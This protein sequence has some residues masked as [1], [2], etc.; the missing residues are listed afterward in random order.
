MTS[1]AKTSRPPFREIWGALPR[2]D[3]VDEIKPVLARY[4][5]AGFTGI[6]VE[7]DYLRWSWAPDPDSGFGGNWRLFNLFDFTR[8]VE[9]PRYRA[10]L[11]EIGAA[12]QAE[13]LELC[14]SFWLPKL[15]QELREYF[16]RHEPSSLGKAVYGVDHERETWC[17]CPGGTGIT[18]FAGMFDEFLTEFPE[19]T[20]LKISIKDNCAFICTEE[21]PHSQGATEAQNAARVFQV[22]QQSIADAGRPP[23]TLLVYPWFWEEGFEEEVVS[24]LKPGHTL[25][26]KYAVGSERA[27]EAGSPAGQLFDSSLLGE[28]PGPIFERWRERV[29]GDHIVDL[30]PWSNSMDA[31]F[32]A[33][34]PTLM[35]VWKRLEMLRDKGVRGIMDFEC[36][37]SPARSTVEAIRLFQET[38]GTIGSEEAAQRIARDVYGVA[39]PAPLV[40][41][42]TLVSRAWDTIPM[43]LSETGIMEPYGLS[44]R[45]GQAWPACAAS[46][47]VR[48]AF[49]EGE[50]GHH[51]HWFSP[52]NFFGFQLSARLRPFFDKM[53]AL[54]AGADQ[55]MQTVAATENAVDFAREARAI[56]GLRL[57]SQ[58]AIN[59]C[60]AALAMKSA[61][62]TAFDHARSRH[63]RT[64]KAMSDL[65][66]QDAE[67]WAN[68]CW[69]PHQMP[70]SQR[71]L[72]FDPAKD[73]NAFTASLHVMQTN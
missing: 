59:F 23:E 63:V 4:R 21:C 16:H 19:V 38:G 46:P 6:W 34:P 67:F 47:I 56:Q 73:R 12:C 68:C 40:E 20:R 11:H 1:A 54:F 43:S 55:L 50:Q 9:A 2:H 57:C 41:A 52:Y 62:D 35:L 18:A 64:L 51:I 36:G 69:H 29:G 8:S 22:V 13:G 32:V 72:G 10:Y 30:L 65:D 48:E 7:N 39:D 58:A 44:P 5:A 71:N 66:R 27:I 3:Q 53:E 15:N 49:A 33:H 42:W 60:D 70:I 14:I 31:M 17:S 25:L 61:N 37:G 24:V 45:L 26:T 28:Y